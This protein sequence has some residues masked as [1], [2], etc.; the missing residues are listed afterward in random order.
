MGRPRKNTTQGPKK[1][2]PVE[3]TPEERAIAQRVA[4][5]ADTSWETIRED[6]LNDFSL[7]HNP[8]DLPP[9]CQ[10]RLEKRE[11][12]YRWAEKKPKRIDELRNMPGPQRWEIVNRTTAPYLP[13]KW[14]DPVHG[15]V[16]VLDQILMYKPWRMHKVV[17]DEKAKLAAIRDKSGDIKSRDGMKDESGTEY[18]AGPQHK[19]GSG[20][21]VMADTADLDRGMEAE[22]E[23]SDLGDLVV[24]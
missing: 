2:K 19:I 6:D 20:D 13:T 3:L 10:E 22:S 23:T 16:Q 11:Y 9:E 5:A 12:A 18:M 15:G 1:E 24:D 17:Q 4:S 8:L 14:F 21:H 7:M